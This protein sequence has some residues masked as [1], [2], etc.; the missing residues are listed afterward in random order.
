MEGALIAPFWLSQKGQNQNTGH[1]DGTAQSQAPELL[2]GWGRTEWDGNPFVFVKRREPP[3]ENKSQALRRCWAKSGCNY[4]PTIQNIVIKTT[5]SSNLA[6]FSHQGGRCVK[7]R[8]WVCSRTGLHS[9]VWWQQLLVSGTVVVRS[10]S[11]GWWGSSRS[12]PAPCHQAQGT[13]ALLQAQ[14]PWQSLGLSV[15]EQG[16]ENLLTG[17]GWDCPGSS[18]PAHHLTLGLLPLFSPLQDKFLGITGIASCY[19]EC[20]L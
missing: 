7:N 1:R 5:L 12:S 8:Y 17:E 4:A 16:A 14:V 19:R 10:H 18:A 20:P 13:P 2:E 11:R 6:Q 9:S 3:S 15:G